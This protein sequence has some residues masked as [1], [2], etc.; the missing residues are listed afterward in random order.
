VR[1]PIRDPKHDVAAPGKFPVPRTIPFEG[2]PIGMPFIAVGLDDQPFA[3]QEID[4]T[5]AWNDDLAPHADAQSSEREAKHGLYSRLRTRIHERE[6]SASS[7]CPGKGARDG[8]HRQDAAVREGVGDDHQ[9]PQAETVGRGGQ[10][11]LRG[12]ESGPYTGCRPV[13]ARARNPR[14]L[15]PGGDSHMHSE[16][17]WDPATVES[18]GA[19]TGEPSAHSARGDEV[20]GSAGCRVPSAS[21]PLQSPARDGAADVARSKARS[22]ELT[23]RMESGLH[24]RIFV[25]RSR[26]PAVS[27]TRRGQTRS[28]PRVGD[29]PTLGR[30]A[31]TS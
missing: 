27:T 20:R 24:P 16:G 26:P 5:N 4:A 23:G 12:V 21:R 13:Q 9:L 15:D 7:W 18:E 10:R 2:I 14:D 29:P 1:L 30:C 28:T 3:D 6:C 31:S 8:G 11:L 17:H 25:R 19:E 22:S